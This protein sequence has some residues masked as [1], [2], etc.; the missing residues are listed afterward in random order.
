ASA[1]IQYIGELVE[2]SESQMLKYRNFGK[3]SLAEIKQKL[4]DLELQLEMVLPDAVKDELTRLIANEQ[5]A[6]E[7]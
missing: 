6:K 1:Q 5:Q 7:E 3:K 4:A 2:K